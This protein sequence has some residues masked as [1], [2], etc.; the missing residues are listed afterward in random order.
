[1][2]DGWKEQEEHLKAKDCEIKARESTINLSKK[3]KNRFFFII[4]E[5]SVGYRFC[6]ILT[7][8]PDTFQKTCVTKLINRSFIIY[9]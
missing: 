3:D 8:E 4:K 9:T 7:K 2:T 6:M 1:M 5:G